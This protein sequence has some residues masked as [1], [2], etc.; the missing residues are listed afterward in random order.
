MPRVHEQR[1]DGFAHCPE[2]RCPG[3]SQEPVPAIRKTTEFTFVDSGGDLP[4][5]EKSFVHFSFA[6][7]DQLACPS[8]GRD[9]ELTETPRKTYAPT[10]GYDQMGLLKYGGRFDPH[11]QANRDNRMGELERQ[12]AEMKELLK[13]KD[14]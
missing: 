3:Y 13:E 9:R 1:V 4:G 5:V 8:C 11:N 12:L 2:A 7:E 10:T 6:D 14:A